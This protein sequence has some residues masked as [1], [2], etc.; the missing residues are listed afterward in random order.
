M[1]Y[2]RACSREELNMCV[3]DIQYRPDS[4]MVVIPETKNCVPRTFLVTDENW[5][6]LFKKYANLKA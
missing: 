6:D 1:G 5:I 3:D 2:N 4:I